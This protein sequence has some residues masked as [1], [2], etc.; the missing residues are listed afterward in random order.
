MFW[1]IIGITLL[2]SPLLLLLG[3]IIYILIPK[4]IRDRRRNYKIYQNESIH[5]YLQETDLWYRRTYYDKKVC[6][7]PQ[8]SFLQFKDF[9]SLNP[10]SW[11]LC[12]CRV[13]KN[14]NDELSFTFTYPEWKKYIKFKNEL[15]KKA[16]EDRRIKEEI[17]SKNKQNEIAIRIL[18][19][20]Q[21]DIER[22]RAESQKN[23]QEAADLINGVNL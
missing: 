19:E 16:E 23:M 11:N 21:K 7:F 9:Y 4:P 13:Y 3:Y 15:D 10:D 17:Q 14:N 22:V 18:E 20:V 5:I 8:I 1:P 2:C 6:E 12:K